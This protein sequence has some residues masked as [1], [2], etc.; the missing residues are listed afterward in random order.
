MTPSRLRHQRGFSLAE[1]IIM[2]AIG[3][4]VIIALAIFV[5]RSFTVSREQFEQVRITEDGRKEMERMSDTLRNASYVDLD[6]N[7]YTMDVGEQW[8]QVGK[9]YEIRVFSNVDIDPEMEL[10][11]YFVDSAEPTELKRG[12]IEP[13]GTAYNSPESIQILSRSVRNLQQETP[14][15]SYYD[16]NGA[17]LAPPVSGDTLKAVARVGI[18]LK[19]DITAQIRP[20]SALLYTEVS[21]RTNRCSAYEGCTSGAGDDSGGTGGTGCVDP[22]GA[23]LPTWSYKSPSFVEDAGQTCKARCETEGSTT[24]CPWFVTFSWNGDPEGYVAAYCSC[25]EAVYPIPLP[26]N[27]QYGQYT[28]YYKDRWNG[29][30]AQGQSG[31]VYCDPGYDLPQDELRPCGYQCSAASPAPSP[32]DVAVDLKVNNSDGPVG[33]SYNDFVTLSWTSANA[34][35]CTASDAWSGTKSPEGSEVNGPLTDVTTPYIFTLTCTGPSGEAQDSVTVNVSI[36]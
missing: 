18:D 12:V 31:E 13:D 30:V 6:G 5:G 14:I 7:G 36:V 35:S 26:D 23:Q 19:I 9:E 8:L 33:V 22:G 16:V 2:V 1:V 10:V 24:T 11:R 34:T 25:Q 32:S 28:Q 21:P 4:V 27:R 20:D 17:A 15:F 29:C 3:T